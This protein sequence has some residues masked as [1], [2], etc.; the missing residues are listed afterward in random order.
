V[1]GAANVLDNVFK[2]KEKN[3][4]TQKMVVFQQSLEA[5]F[6]K[7]AP[8]LHLTEDALISGSEA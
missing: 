6:K 5:L 2:A 3:D 7:A 1:E 8:K 4:I